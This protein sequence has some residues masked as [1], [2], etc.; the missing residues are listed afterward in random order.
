MECIYCK[1][2][3]KEIKGEVVFED[4]SSLAVLDVRPLSPGHTLVL[5]KSHSS[6]ILELPE[7]QVGPLFLVVKK[8]IEKL[9]KVL[10]PEGF[11]IGI[12]QGK[13]G[14]QAI[15]H[16][17]IHIIPRWCNDGGGSIHSIVNNPPKESLEEIA[18]KIRD[19]EI[20]DQ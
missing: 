13:A 15:D 10:N 17:H 19:T 20:K 4:E 11:T 9:V 1:I 12:N 3:N 8:I 6:S 16:L 18:K 14:G 5:P 2:I 7:N